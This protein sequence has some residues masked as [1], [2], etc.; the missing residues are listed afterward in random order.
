MPNT[1]LF[2]MSSTDPLLSVSLSRHLEQASNLLCVQANS[3]SYRQRDEEMSSSSRATGWRRSPLIGAVVCLCAALR[4]QLFAIEGKD[5]RIMRRG[6]ISSCQ[7]AA[8]SET[9]KC[10]CS[11]LVSS[12]ITST[13]TFT[14]T[15][16]P[17]NQSPMHPDSL[18]RRWHYSITYL[19][20]YLQVS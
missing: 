2:Q 20:T 18:L 15:L 4:V 19:L 8:T 13:Q 16:L 9:V 10:C 12:A 11:S 3:A 6:I 7:S 17:S 1:C 14:F 5:G